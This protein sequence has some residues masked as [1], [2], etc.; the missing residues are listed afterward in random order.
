M[1]RCASQLWSPLRKSNLALHRQYWREMASPAAW[2]P[3]VI[4]LW[5]C[6]YSCT[7]IHYSIASLTPGRESRVIMVF[8]FC[9][10]LCFQSSTETN[11][12]SQW[13][14]VRKVEL[15]AWGESE[16]PLGLSELWLYPS[17]QGA[18]HPGSSQG[19]CFD[20]YCWLFAH[21]SLSLSLSFSLSPYCC[22]SDWTP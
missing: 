4:L 2:S 8:G 7:G 13:W 21:L 5:P 18:A 19:P 6:R 1:V 22:R 20:Y 12:A 9:A 17:H 3:Q 15:E 16:G 11:M 14:D 10:K